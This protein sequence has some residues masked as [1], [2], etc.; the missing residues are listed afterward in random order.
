MQSEEK[1]HSSVESRS[2][3][4]GEQP[5][6]RPGKMRLGGPTRK[7]CWHLSETTQLQELLVKMRGTLLRRKS[8]ETLPYS[9]DQSVLKAVGTREE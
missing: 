6:T 7:D 5:M 3:A 8:L 2:P 9:R 4:M 1:K